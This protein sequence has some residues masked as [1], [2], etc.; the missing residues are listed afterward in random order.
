MADE[1]RPLEDASSA[2][3]DQ[4]YEKVNNMLGTGNQ[5]FT[6][7]VPAWPLNGATHQYDADSRYSMLIK[8]VVVQESEAILSNI[9]YNDILRPLDPA[10]PLCATDLYQNASNEQE[11]E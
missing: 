3:I 10:S 8:P 4:I 11:K 9:W 6:M 2:M 1:K 5:L 7:E